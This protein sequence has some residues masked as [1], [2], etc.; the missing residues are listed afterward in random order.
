M[1][2]RMSRRNAG[3]LPSSRAPVGPGARVAGAGAGPVRV[4]IVLV[5]SGPS[6]RGQ[7]AQPAEGAVRFGDVARLREPGSAQQPGELR[8]GQHRES[9][10][11]GAAREPVADEALRVGPPA[12][13]PAHL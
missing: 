7:G 9:L 8:S 10:L 5:T 13:L 11:S 12:C 3:M 2:A 1:A 4:V 6:L